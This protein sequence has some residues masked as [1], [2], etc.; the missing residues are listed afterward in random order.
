MQAFSF[1]PQ[2]LPMVF[3]QHQEM[4]TVKTLFDH[5]LTL[6]PHMSI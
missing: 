3:T 5:L 1:L 2:E 4:L 6:A